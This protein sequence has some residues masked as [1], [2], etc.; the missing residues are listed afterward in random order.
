MTGD[1][2]WNDIL[3]RLARSVEDR[4]PAHPDP[5][6]FL[7]HDQGRL[8]PSAA[9]D[10]EEHLSWCRHC[11][12]AWRELSE[13]LED[14]PEPSD[15]REKAADWQALQ[16]SLKR[17][18]TPPPV[19]ADTTV[20]RAVPRARLSP[21][22]AATLAVA[23]AGAALWIVNLSG[24]LDDS[25]TPRPNVPIY[26]LVPSVVERAGGEASPLSIE[27]DRNAVLILNARAE[28]ESRSYEV[29]ILDAEGHVEWTISHLR[30]TTFG[31]FTLELPRE[32]L[33]P[34]VYRIVV[35]PTGSESPVGQ[36][37][38]RI[39]ERPLDPPG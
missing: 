2:S 10:F 6:T 38:I 5:E 28:L 21:I 26:D 8:L 37:P 23:L 9:E 15:P 18:L 30:L 16:K 33:A 32:S 3:K 4:L 7:A 13:F 17:E 31:N 39:I 34:G 24:R 25:R 19:Q 11:A 22:L 1:P 27:L 20:L 29:R 35:Q 12:T 14:E 36:F